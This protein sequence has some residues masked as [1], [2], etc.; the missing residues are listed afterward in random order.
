MHSLDRISVTA[1]TSHAERSPL[2][3]Y[4]YKNTGDGNGRDG[5][6]N[7][8]EREREIRDVYK[9]LQGV[10]S[11]S[12]THSLINISVTAPTDQA[13]RSPLKFFARSNTGDGNGRE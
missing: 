7:E 3:L 12:S 2:K 9:L 6:T 11:T 1:P 5:E 8:R 4:A 10:S 13:E